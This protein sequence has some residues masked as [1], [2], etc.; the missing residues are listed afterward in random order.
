[1]PAL[2]CSVVFYPAS[3]TENGHNILSR[4]YDFA[5][6]DILTG[7]RLPKGRAAMARPYLFEIHPDRGYSSLS[8]CAFDYLGGVLDGIN[9]E[10]LVVSILSVGGESVEKFGFEPSSEVGM[11]ELM[12]MRY[13]LDNCKNVEEAKQA[14]LSLKHYYCLIPCHYIVGDRTGKS[15]IFELSAGGNRGYIIDGK[16]PQCV[17]NHLVFN[18]EKTLEKYKNNPTSSLRRYTKLEESIRA[19]AKFSLEEIAA[20]N[21]EVAVPPGVHSNPEIA[22]PRTLWYAQYDLENLTLTVKF[23]LSEKPDPTNEKMATLEYSP[24]M[25]F[26]LKK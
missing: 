18:H 3:A 25:T 16:G 19:K 7:K 21:S 8:L 14:L 2:G 12:S 15:F 26:E 6:G 5:T 4:N 24:L 13:L 23:Y 17:T 11:H 1:M 9:S 20:I 22:L 10:G